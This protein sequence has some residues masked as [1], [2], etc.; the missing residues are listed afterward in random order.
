M[1]PFA[2]CALESLKSFESLAPADAA[3]TAWLS[4]ESSGWSNLFFR[5]GMDSS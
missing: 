3:D 2:Q 1:V 4:L 5:V